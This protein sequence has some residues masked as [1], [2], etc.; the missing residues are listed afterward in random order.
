MTFM[1]ISFLAEDVTYFAVFTY[2]SLTFL[3]GRE[4]ICL[5]HCLVLGV[6]TELPPSPQLLQDIRVISL[7]SLT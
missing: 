4:E 5:S 3:V 7:R 1:A 2:R 6:D